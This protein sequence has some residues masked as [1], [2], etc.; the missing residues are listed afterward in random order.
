MNASDDVRQADAPRPR[1]PLRWLVLLITLLLAGGVG[2]HWLSRPQQLSGLILQQAGKAL[3][4]MITAGSADYR[5][6][7][8][9]MLELRDV[10]ARQPGAAVP[11]LTT[12]RVR[13]DLPWSTIRSRGAQLAIERIELDAPVLN[14]AALQAWLAS[15]PPSDMPLRIPDLDAGLQVRDGRLDGGDWQIEAIRIHVPELHPGQVLQG[16]VAG[17]YRDAG[18]KVATELAVTLSEPSFD[19]ELKATGPLRIEQKTWRMEG[20]AQLSGP[21][22]MDDGAVQIAPTTFGY[23]ATIHSSDTRLPLRL[24]AHGPFGY[25]DG[26]V[27]WGLSSLLLRSDEPDSLIPDLQ[28][29]GSIAFGQRLVLRLHGQLDDWPSTW[30]ALPPPLGNQ[31]APLPFALDYVGKANLGDV[32]SL[33]LQREATTFAARFRLPQVLDWA[34]APAAGSPLPPLDGQLDTPELQIAGATLQG[35]QITLD[36]PDISDPSAPAA[37][38]ATTP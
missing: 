18:T 28:S 1:H 16:S 30:P 20:H 7:G 24:G 2:L 32:A 33:R 25:G 15:R 22:R 6:R 34:D 31:T 5:L 21:L 10:D 3:G 36:D 23:N 37:D 35:V 27:R 17:Q 13:I 19:T 29:S 12:Q 9:P 8:T 11:V 4:L 14:L 26:I 38:T